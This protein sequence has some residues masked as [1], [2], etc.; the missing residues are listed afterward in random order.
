MRRHNITKYVLLPLCL[1]LQLM[2]ITVVLFKSKNRLSNYKIIYPVW[3]YY[4]NFSIRTLKIILDFYMIL[5]FVLLMMYF[6]SQKKQK[7]PLTYRQRRILIYIFILSFL[8]FYRCSFVFV[9]G[10]LSM[11]DKI[12]SDKNF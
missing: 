6:V 8:Q 2:I 10:N 9:G 7:H 4:F 3:F 5:Q 11:I 1:L 12:D